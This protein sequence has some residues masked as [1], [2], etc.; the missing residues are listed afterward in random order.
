MSDDHFSDGEG[1]VV[2]EIFLNVIFFKHQI[3][4]FKLFDFFVSLLILLLILL[5][6]IL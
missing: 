3:V 1:R 4:D 6:L 2:I 5:F